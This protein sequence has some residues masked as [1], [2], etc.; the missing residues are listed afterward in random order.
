MSPRLDYF[1][2]NTQLETPWKRNGSDGKLP[3]VNFFPT[4]QVS[5][6]DFEFFNEYVLQSVLQNF[7]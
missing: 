2:V 7:L 3:F 4:L 6:E 1:L 5:R